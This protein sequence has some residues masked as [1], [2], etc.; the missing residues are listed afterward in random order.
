MIENILQSS[1]LKVSTFESNFIELLNQL[2]K[3]IEM[4]LKM[5]V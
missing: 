4:S 5:A 3:N 2:Q 1:K